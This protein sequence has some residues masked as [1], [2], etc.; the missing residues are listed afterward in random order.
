MSMKHNKKTE[1]KQS[2]N[3]HTEDK[4][5]AKKKIITNMKVT[6]GVQLGPTEKVR[7]LTV[8]S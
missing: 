1:T 3:G 4:K 7:F 5:P 8:I 6:K 2:K